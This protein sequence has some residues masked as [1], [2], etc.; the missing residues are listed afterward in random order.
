[1]EQ[2]TGQWFLCCVPLFSRAPFCQC[3]FSIGRCSCDGSFQ[4]GAVDRAVVLC[5]VPLISRAPFCQ[6][7]FS[8]GRCSC[9]VS[10]QCG[11]GGPGSGLCCV[12]LISRAPFCQCGFSRGRCSS[13]VF[14]QFEAVDRAVICAVCV[15]LFNLGR[16][17]GLGSGFVLCASAPSGSVLS[18]RCQSQSVQV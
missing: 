13:D 5:C 3:G 4:C 17:S 18:V 6:C 9:D 11:A 12:P 2:W 10:F 8:R 15:P 16:S 14:V 1:M 7:G